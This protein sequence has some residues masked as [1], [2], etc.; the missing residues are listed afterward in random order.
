MI[1]EKQV[2]SLGYPSTVPYP[3][4]KAAK[5]QHEHSQ[6]TSRQ[7]RGAEEEGHADVTSDACTQAVPFHRSLTA[8]Q[9]CSN[10]FNPQL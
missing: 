9:I 5:T 6:P 4:P 7:M 2:D 8:R 3:M 1:S 10:L